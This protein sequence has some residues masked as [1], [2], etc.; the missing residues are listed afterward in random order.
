MRVEVKRVPQDGE[1]D[2]SR[3]WEA[4]NLTL[5]DGLF[6]FSGPKFGHRASGMVLHKT[7]SIS[8]P[9]ADYHFSIEVMVRVGW[10]GMHRHERWFIRLMEVSI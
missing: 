1:E 7:L 2:K 4:G 6:M 8:Y 5:S 10:K 9:L 3:P